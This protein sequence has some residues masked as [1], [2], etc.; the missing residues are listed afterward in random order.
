MQR[1]HFKNREMKRLFGVLLSLLLVFSMLPISAL[2]DE[3]VPD[4][5]SPLIETEAS[6]TAEADA[7]DAAD[8]DAA[9]A[10]VNAADAADVDKTAS[11][12]D[13]DDEGACLEY[14]EEADIVTED[15][16]I[17]LIQEGDEDFLEQ[18]AG[19]M[20]PRALLAAAG[21]VSTESELRLAVSGAPASDPV[22]IT[23]ANSI[24]LTG[25]PLSIPLGTNITLAAGIPG[26][27]ELIGENGQNVISIP[28]VAKLTIDGIVVTHASGANGGGASISSGGILVMESGGISGNNNR[29]SGGGVQVTGGTLFMYGGMISDN[30]AGSF[31]GGVYVG[32]NGTLTLVGGEISGNTATGLGPSGGGSGGGVYIN[33]GLFTMTGGSVADNKTPGGGGGVYNTVNGAFL[34]A[35]GEISGNTG[36]SGGVRN[37]GAFTIEGGII[38]GNHGEYFGGGVYNNGRSVFTMSGGEISGNDAPQGGGVYNVGSNPFVMEGGVIKGNTVGLVGGGVY[39]G[40][41]SVFVMTGGEISGNTAADNGGGV[42][43]N[44]VFEMREGP[45]GKKPVI[46]GNAVTGDTD[47][48]RGGGVFNVVNGS[49]FMAG[50]EISGN[51]AVQG[52]GVGNYRSGS[53]YQPIFIMSGGEISGNTAVRGGGLYNN[54]TF[55]LYGGAIS[56]NE[57]DYGGGAFNSSPSQ[58]VE[59]VFAM[60]SGEVRGNT[61]IDGG[62]VFNSGLLVVSGGKFYGNTAENDG[63]GIWAAHE[64]LDKVSVGAGA[65]FSDNSARRSYGRS[66]ADDL[67]YAAQIQCTQWTAP[68]TQGYNNFDISYSYE[69]TII[70]PE[71]VQ[72]V[73][74][75]TVNTKTVEIWQGEM[76]PYQTIT[77]YSGANHGSVT[78]TT[79]AQ[80]ALKE[81][82]INPKNGNLDNKHKQFND[83]VVKNSNHFTFAKL[84][85]A[86]LK[87]GGAELVLVVGNKIDTVGTGKAF[88]NSAGKL[89]L[90]FGVSISSSKFGAVAFTNLL[91]PKNGNIHSDKVFSHDNKTVLNMPAADKNGY[92]YLYVHFDSLKYNSYTEESAVVWKVT[93]EPEIIWTETFTSYEEP[94]P[95]VVPFKVFDADSNEV[96]EAA[97]ANPTPGLY[98]VVFYDPYLTDPVKKVVEV[99]Y[100]EALVVEYVANHEVPGSN[101]VKRIDLPFLEKDLVITRKTGGK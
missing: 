17:Y 88:I 94:L 48:N 22:T 97:W 57:A 6:E 95:V 71:V 81:L 24:T 32:N 13:V 86:D 23:L 44:G 33:S 9:D 8:A 39:N 89:E 58:T 18:E 43:N 69:A 37:D 4:L 64:T 7:A 54:S 99:V 21:D 25:D 96:D 47:Y 77:Q 91:E 63:G 26:S 61:A 76:T 1:R 100:N 59:A 92:I 87:N 78:V 5:E 73:T 11:M 74:V 41:S 93:K 27:V 12:E 83:L 75:T 80:L 38:K 16:D 60:M 66:P 98:T 56:G 30:T 3:I 29:F 67:L 79:P 51:T 34:L 35:G 50:G 84:A 65:A 55:Q 31:G 85:V 70:P 15:D 28:G 42:I 46:S 40:G 53:A 52:G 36:S 90:S 20:A 19:L 82:F 101:T 68:L 2:A 14:T 45:E 10:D 72:N 62:G 49:F